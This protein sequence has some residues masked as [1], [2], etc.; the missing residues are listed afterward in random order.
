MCSDGGAGNDILSG[1]PGT[2]TLNGGL[3][4]DTYRFDTI[5][6][7]GND[8]IN[9]SG[10]NDLIV[11][12]GFDLSGLNFEQTLNNNLVGSASG[13]SVTIV[14]QYAGA[15]SKVESL[16][17]EGITSIPG[18]AGGA[19]IFGY[20][21]GSAPYLLNTDP[22][23][24]GGDQNDLI[25]GTN[26]GEVLNGNGGNDLLFG[27][28]GAD[29]LNGDA[30][31]DLLVGGDGNDALH[32]GDGNDTLIGGPGQD[33]VT[34]DAGDD[35]I[36][37]DITS[38]NVDTIDAGTG[39]D[40]LVLSGFAFSGSG[41]VK[42]DLSSLTDQV[43]SIDD[44]TDGTAQQNFENLDASGLSFFNSIVVTGSDGANIITG[45][46]GDDSLNG[47]LGND[48]YRYGANFFGSFSGSGNDTINDSGGDDRIVMSGSDLSGLNFEQ[49][50]T[51]LVGS[52]FGNTLITVEEQYD[53]G[54]N[55]ESLQFE[56]F[57]SIPG[58]AAGGA[59]MFGYALGS[60]PYLLNTD[61]GST[62]NGGDQNDLIA[63]SSAG[64][65]TLNGNGGKDLLFGNEGTD[66]LNG[67][68]GDD[69]LVGGDGADTL[70]GGDGNDTL[71]GGLGEDTVNGGTGDDHIGMD[72]TSGNVDVA[73]GGVGTD[74]LVLSGG[75]PLTG[76]VEVD[77]SVADQVV[78]IGGTSDDTLVQDGFENLD[79]SGLGSSVNATGSDGANIIIGSSGNDIINGGA[80]NDTLDGG[81]G[82]DVLDG[83]AGNDTYVV[84]N[85]NDTV[86]ES[87]AG[88]AG[89]IDLV[90]SSAVSFI[91]G[92]NVENLTLI[93]AAIAGTG[94]ALNNILT[95]NS[96]NNS[97]DGKAGN[98]NMAGGLGDDTYTVDVAGDVVTEALNAGTDTVVTSLNYT[99]GAN[100]ENLEL[101]GPAVTGTGNTL[102]NV[103]T[104]T[105]GA[106]TLA[107]L[108][109]NDTLRGGAGNDTLNGGNDNDTYLF[110]SGD[111]QDLIQDNNGCMDKILFDD[112]INGINHQDLV[113]SK[114]AN[115]L[116]IAIHDGS[117]SDQITV[118]NWFVGTANRTETIQAGDGQVLLS[119]QVDQL[120]QAMS[121]FTTDTH[122]SWDDAS[123]GAGTAQQQTQFQGILAANWQ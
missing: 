31:D 89:G 21:L 41:E 65:E 33:T 73:H 111:G 106:N 26:A 93:G 13:D 105:G 42:V 55:V 66:T 6:I 11:M 12:N 121:Q 83:D 72:V 14:G 114:Q 96:G 7:S 118:Q 86:T 88:A 109:G 37:M 4:N 91:L 70:D 29:T 108:A 17:F 59:S 87:L 44:V 34:G 22:T 23:H 98:D 84:D 117:P 97:L 20:A 45:G 64:G 68:A 43:V 94:N 80:G 95:G 119:T 115:N 62:R 82:N 30:G 51:S 36:G 28:E 112:G 71:V 19:S 90:Q 85:A 39:N 103:L 50:G 107:G 5:G 78:F 116:R 46:G 47:G 9:D 24:N 61:T 100:V 52:A 53:A 120:I 69:L 48:T 32:G 74:T 123:G 79:A 102:N 113:I 25:A 122:L 3:G 67:G 40:T 15:S 76:V 35:H 63:G 77:L 110:G 1:G 18:F 49:T 57:A 60:A 16:Q 27:N 104:G 58:F 8:T 92:D 99:L 54:K 2:D 75:D 38:G 10:G 81:K 56:G 101:T